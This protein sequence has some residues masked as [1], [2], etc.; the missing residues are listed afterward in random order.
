MNYQI[1]NA[2]SMAPEAVKAL[3]AAVAGGGGVPLFGAPED[4]AARLQMLSDCGLDGVLLTFVDYLGGL[5]AFAD[6]VLPLL[7]QAGLRAV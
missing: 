4:I 5:R 7:R 1:K 2:A 3:R 6:D